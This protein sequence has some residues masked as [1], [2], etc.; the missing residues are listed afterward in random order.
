MINVKTL[1]LEVVW[2]CLFCAINS[3]SIASTIG[4]NNE[5][6]PDTF[7]T[8]HLIDAQNRVSFSDS[9]RLTEHKV[10]DWIKTRIKVAKLQNKMKENASEYDNVVQA[11]YK[12]RK[13]LL[14][15]LGWTV[16][17]FEEAKE[18]IQGAVAAMD[19]AEDLEASKA[20]HQEDIEEIKANEFYTDQQKDELINT[21]NKMRNKQKNQFIDPTKKD[22]P[23]VRPYKEIFE[24]MTDWIA[25]NIPNPPKL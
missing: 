14:V 11:F 24:E 25:G 10:E 15:S 2:I 7:V 18:R 23:V 13:D 6:K 19:I 1:R 9:L 22:W 21:M 8:D 16:Q 12:E 4:D 17:R 20:D 3:I 5:W